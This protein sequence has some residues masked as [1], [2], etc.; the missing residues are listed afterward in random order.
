MH[1]LV[2]M[3]VLTCAKCISTVSAL[4]LHVTKFLS[5]I[6]WYLG[7]YFPLCVYQFERKAQLIFTVSWC[8]K[9]QL[10]FTVSWCVKAQ[11]TFTVSLRTRLI[12]HSLWVM[13]WASCGVALFLHT[14]F[15]WHSPTLLNAVHK[16]QRIKQVD[17]SDLYLGG[18]HFECRLGCRLPWL[19]YFMFCLI[20]SRQMLGKYLKLSC[21]HFLLHLSSS[22]P[23]SIKSFNLQS[24]SHWECH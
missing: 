10:T 14:L 3:S 16:Q 23:S 17:S 5:A 6:S 4:H 22:M 1:M 2:W 15:I 9:A 13:V 20:P 24:L 7:K 8:V 19:R 21:A 12:S 11:L 18:A